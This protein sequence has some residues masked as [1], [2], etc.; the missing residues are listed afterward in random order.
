MGK[1]KSADALGDLA[2]AA[3][4]PQARVRDQALKSFE[5]IAAD[6]VDVYRRYVAEAAD[7]RLHARAARLAALAR[8]A[9]AARNLPGRH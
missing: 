1:I 5:R 4:D 7:A 2:K 3:D 9:F 8:D 6:N